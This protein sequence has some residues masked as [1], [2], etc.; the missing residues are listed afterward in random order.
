MESDEIGEKE[1]QPTFQK[2]KDIWEYN[3]YRTWYIWQN[4]AEERFTLDYIQREHQFFEFS[5]TARDTQ[6][7]L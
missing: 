3:S 2:A 6:E 5:W 7:I 1:R 4:A